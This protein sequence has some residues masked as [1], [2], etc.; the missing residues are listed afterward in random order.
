MP[1]PRVAASPGELL[2]FLAGIAHVEGERL[3]IDDEAA[4]RASGHPRRR[5]DRDVRR[6]R[7]HGRG[8]ALDRL[9]SVAG[10]GL[11]VGEH[12]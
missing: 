12:P 9:G 8:G 2:A 6:R 3:V 5:L 11:A 10:A 7:G 4:F 1:A